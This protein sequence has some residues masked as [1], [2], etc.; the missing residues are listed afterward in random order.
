MPGGSSATKFQVDVKAGADWVRSQ[1]HWVNV[2][3]GCLIFHFI[4]P[5]ARSLVLVTSPL[6][7]VR[8]EET[9]NI[10]TIHANFVRV[11]EKKN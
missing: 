7:V 2:R 11:N 9:T 4:V 10:Q 6:T 3:P 8:L 5:C 1:G